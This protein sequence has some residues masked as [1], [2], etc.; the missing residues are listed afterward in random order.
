MGISDFFGKKDGPVTPPQKNV[1]RGPG[2]KFVSK[3]KP[4]LKIEEPALPPVPEVKPVTQA[5]PPVKNSNDVEVVSFYNQDIRKFY[6]GNKW[7]FAVEDML[8]LTGMNA[9]TTK[10]YLDKI[11]NSSEHKK[12]VAGIITVVDSIDCIDIDGLTTLLPILRETK[13]IFPGPF[14][15][16]LKNIST[17]PH[18]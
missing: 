10:D 16:W 13:N 6:S 1:L 4:V 11:K 8:P 2:G 5:P 15:D 17:F 18:P 12:V 14:P 7:Y 3:K 9:S